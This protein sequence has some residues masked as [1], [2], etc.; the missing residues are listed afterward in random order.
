MNN[1]IRGNIHTLHCHV[2]CYIYIYMERERDIYLYMYRY[3]YTISLLCA[4]LGVCK[5]C[6]LLLWLFSHCHVLHA[7]SS[8]VAYPLIDIMYGDS[9]QGY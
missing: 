9:R 2:L 5:H 3:I 1:P 7:L 4:G 8:M 6:C